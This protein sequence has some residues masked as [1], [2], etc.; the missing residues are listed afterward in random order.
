[1]RNGKG[2]DLDLPHFEGLSPLEQAPGNIL[3]TAL[4]K[5]FARERIGE[6]RDPSLAQKNFQPPGVIT[7]FVGKQ[8]PIEG[9]RINVQQ[10]EPLAKLL[11]AQAGIKEEAGVTS[12]EHGGIPAASTP[13]DRKPHTPGRLRTAPIP[14]ETQFSVS[15][16]G[17]PSPGA[18][19]F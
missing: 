16:R 13:Q 11:G 3:A 6:D 12:L 1:M 8:N 18:R 7:V 17:D 4:S 9:I 15:D 2:V 19:F 10:L 14:R 5:G